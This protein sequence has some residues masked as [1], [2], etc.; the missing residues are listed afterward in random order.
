MKY[1]DDVVNP[2]VDARLQDGYS[3]KRLGKRL[4]MSAQYISRAEHGTYSDLNKSLVTYVSDVLGIPAPAVMHRYKEFQKET[5]RRTAMNLNPRVLSR[6]TSTKSGHELFA[7]WRACY[8]PSAVAFSNAFCVHPEVVNTYEDGIRAV[9][10][11]QVKRALNHVKLLDPNWTEDP[12][13]GIT[14]PASPFGPVMKRNTKLENAV[15]QHLD[16]NYVMLIPGQRSQEP[17]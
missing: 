16:A 9:M 8:W 13:P 3:L 1:F 7:S 4:D 10:P 14:P 5:R 6:G 11:D 17:A 2:I 15:A 12:A